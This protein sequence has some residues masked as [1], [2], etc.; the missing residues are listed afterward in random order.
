MRRRFAGSDEIRKQP[1][2]RTSLLRLSTLP[3]FQCRRRLFQESKLNTKTQAR[4][5]RHDLPSPGSMKS[6]QKGPASRLSELFSV[7]TSCRSSPAR[8]PSKCAGAGFYYWWLQPRNRSRADSAGRWP[9]TDGW[10]LADSHPLAGLGQLDRDVAS[11]AAKLL[12]QAPFETSRNGKPPESTL[13]WRFGNEGIPSRPGSCPLRQRPRW[14][15]PPRKSPGSW[16]WM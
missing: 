12:S 5:R 3:L 10:F 7:S 14:S 15:Y 9:A 8:E 2:G 6:Q 4:G 11:G 1:V 16:N 13:R